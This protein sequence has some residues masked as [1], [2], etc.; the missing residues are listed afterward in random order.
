MD[1][2]DFAVKIR[3]LEGLL[4]KRKDK[5]A[6]E[7]ATK[8]A[9]VIPFFKVLGY[10]TYDPEEIIPEYIADIGDKKGEKV[11]YAI[12][13]DGQVVILVEVKNLKSIPEQKDTYQL[14]R[15]FGSGNVSFAIL[16]NGIEYKFFTDIDKKHIMDNEAFFTVKIDE[17]IKES[18]I[19]TLQ[20]FSKKVFQPE[21]MSIKAREIKYINKIK[22]YLEKQFKVPEN[23]F[24]KFFMFKAKIQRPWNKKTVEQFSQIVAKA[25]E[26]CANQ[27][28]LKSTQTVE[29][30]IIEAIIPEKG[31]HYREKLRVKFWTQLL[32]YAKTKTKLHSKVSPGAGCGCGMGAGT[33]GLGYNYV[34]FQHKSRV[35][36]YIDKGDKAV[37]KEIFDRLFD[38]KEEI[39]KIF[40]GT[41]DWER[42]ED[43]RACRIKKDLDLGGYRDEEQNWPKIHEAMVDE[44]IRFHKAISPHIQYL[45]K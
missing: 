32:M 10:D 45:S 42:K 15:Y 4:D 19:E 11:D 28:A 17:F 16:T 13:K 5:V 33:S 39:E 38:A 41:L 21:Q 22:E 31:S 18:D 24:T 12:T 7:E 35:E 2:A 25:F 3:E 36:L 20:L 14:K 37:N 30:K 44:M 1:F 34:I 23:D 40:G 27:F 43:R 9:L 26:L 8:M 6:T 29:R